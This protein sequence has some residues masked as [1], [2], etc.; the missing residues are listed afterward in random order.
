[1]DFYPT[2]FEKAA[3]LFHSL[4]CN[5]PFSNGNKRTAVIAVDLFL[6]ANGTYLALSERQM[7]ELAK[8]TATHN[9]RGLPA[10]SL[11]NTIT[12]RLK[13]FSLPFEEL[14]REE[15]YKEIYNHAITAR[16]AVRNHP[17]N[18]LYRPISI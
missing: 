14:A 7:Y 15:R 17:A 10:E 4:I 6:V 3:P 1:M 18:S 13:K 8:S 16:Q 5:H 2:L 9:E 11:L 12:S